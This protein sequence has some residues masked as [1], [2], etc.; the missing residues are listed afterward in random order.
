M[1]LP[2][3]EPGTD[4]V[5]CSFSF[6]PTLLSFWLQR[7]ARNGGGFLSNPIITRPPADRPMPGAEARAP[8]RLP[9][10]P[11]ARLSSQVSIFL[12]NST[13][14]F[15]L[16][17]KLAFWNLNSENNC[18]GNEPPMRLKHTPWGKLGY[19]RRCECSRKTKRT[20]RGTETGQYMSERCQ[21]A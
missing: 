9:G 12:R 11:R 5:C 6:S 1:V 2:P 17:K 8:L 3:A 7:K 13:F 20:E 10:Q 4:T 19:K 14:F 21:E 18:H 15:S 16:S